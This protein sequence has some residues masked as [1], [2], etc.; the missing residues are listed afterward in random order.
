M[1]REFISSVL[2]F[3][4]AGSHSVVTHCEMIKWKLA[5]LL[6]FIHFCALNKYSFKILPVAVGHFFLK[7]WS[8]LQDF[9]G[10]MGSGQAF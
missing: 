10:L 7:V 6:L 5:C 2:T 8:I 1:E 4:C 9:L 3:C